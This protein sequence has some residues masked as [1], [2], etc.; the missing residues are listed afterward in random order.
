VSDSLPRKDF[1]SIDNGI[2]FLYARESFV[3]LLRKSMP[4]SK[5][6]VRLRLNVL[7]W[8]TSEACKYSITSAV[9]MA[10]AMTSCSS[11][12]LGI[13]RFTSAYA[14][15]VYEQMMALIQSRSLNYYQN[16]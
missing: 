6:A 8:C 10:A 16:F 7:C 9:V 1:F 13:E 5:I 2:H 4:Q 11:A 3:G 14:R 15:Q 12:M